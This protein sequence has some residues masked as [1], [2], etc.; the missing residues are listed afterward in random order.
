MYTAIF[1]KKYIE[2]YHHK[3]A[4]VFLTRNPH[5]LMFEFAEKLISHE[6]DVY[7]SINSIDYVPPK[8]ISEKINILQISSDESEQAGYKGG[9]LLIPDG[10]A[11]AWCKAIYYFC[12]LNTTSYD[13]IWFIEDD[14]F[15][16]SVHTLKNLDTLYPSHSSDVL[17]TD[18]IKT[19]VDSNHWHYQL[20][21]GLIDLPWAG[22]MVMAIRV[23]LRLIREIKLLT[24]KN[25]KLLM[26]ELLFHTVAIHHGFNI[27]VAPELKWLVTSKIW[28]D[29]EIHENGLFHPIKSYERHLELANENKLEHYQNIYHILL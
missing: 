5:T 19:E 11:S 21:K 3:H 18:Y 28:D 29:N 22:G 13:A 7:F 20:N 6:Y 16:P 23:S 12:E 14:V 24:R 25:K 17:S 15:I 9:T 2:R 27:V 26:A 8:N 4:I 10:G 1:E